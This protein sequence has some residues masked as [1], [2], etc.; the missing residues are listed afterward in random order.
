MLVGKNSHQPQ[1]TYYIYKANTET[2]LY[3]STKHLNV[4]YNFKSVK[5]S[6]LNFL[7]SK[8]RLATKKSV[9]IT[10]RE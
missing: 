4:G 3:N 7:F 1:Y 2:H 10:S 9:K 5:E 6:P 8:R